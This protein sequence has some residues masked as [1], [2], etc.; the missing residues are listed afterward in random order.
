MM[1]MAIILKAEYWEYQGKGIE[2]SRAGLA[3]T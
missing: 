2:S 1:K 3:V